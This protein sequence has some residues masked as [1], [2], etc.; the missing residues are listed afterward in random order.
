M[1]HKI[2]LNQEIWE[3]IYASNSQMSIWP[4]S[5]I[6][7]LTY[8]HASK[9]LSKNKVEVLELGCGAGA[10]IQFFQN[11]NFNY[12]AIEYSKTIV[13]NLHIRFPNLKDQIS[14]GNFVNANLGKEN[15]DLIVDRA[16]ITHNNTADINSTLVSVYNALKVGGIFIGVDWFSNKHSDYQIGKLCDD[17]NT[18]NNFESG[19]FY[20]AGKVH[21]SDENHLRDLFKFFEIC[22]LQEKVI[23]TKEP[24]SQK[25][26]SS[27][28]IVAKR[29]YE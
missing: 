4:W 23:T 10:N 3:K 7:S 13:N 28:N 25:V 11:L 12:R 2:D 15:Y 16:A 9:L 18:K 5:D 1:L 17:E 6:I 14:V 29:L 19:Q 26:F 27:W 20:N 8:R 21:F 24:K 22:L